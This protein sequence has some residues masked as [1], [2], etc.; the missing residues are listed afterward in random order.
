MMHSSISVRQRNRST[1]AR[2]SLRARKSIDLGSCLTVSHSVF[3]LCVKLVEQ[4]LLKDR[5]EFRGLKRGGILRLRRPRVTCCSQCITQDHV[6]HRIVR[7]KIYG[8]S[9]F[10]DRI[11][12]VLLPRKI[13]SRLNVFECRDGPKCELSSIDV[14]SS[15]NRRC[16]PDRYKWSIGISLAGDV[17]TSQYSIAY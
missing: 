6:G 3:R 7:V 1:L 5:I 2:L 13:F 15:I 14:D 16:G 12:D 17:C 4:A 11:S 10:A 9:R 8:D